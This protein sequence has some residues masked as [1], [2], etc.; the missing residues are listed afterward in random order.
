M[1]SL[2]AAIT[3]KLGE[4]TN[5]GRKIVNHIS[6]GLNDIIA[7][8]ALLL[9]VTSIA[10]SA[11]DEIREYY[12]DFESAGSYL[13]AGLAKGIKDSQP[14][15]VAAAEAL[16]NAVNAAFA[17]IEDIK[18]PSGVFEAF[19]NYLGAG[20]VVG[21]KDSEDSA[22]NAS[23]DLGKTVTEG[24][25]AGLSN[26]ADVV[27]N[28][29]DVEPTITPVLD[30]SDIESKLANITGKITD[31]LGLNSSYDIISSINVDSSNNNDD[32]VD[33]LDELI[34]VEKS[35]DRSSY[36]INGITYAGN[37]DLD[38]AVRIIVRAAKVE[39]RR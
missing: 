5:A 32:I 6:L 37:S 33:K 28:V 35:A 26:F 34:D 10:T 30:A 7:R 4:F 15:A 39:R 8:T 22:Y 36:N 31:T 25:E 24:A 13:V 11:K 9:N 1:N 19:G 3:A 2:T 20:L 14:S 38:D 21:I 27:E 16:A 18:S 12:E 17:K 29:E 23:E